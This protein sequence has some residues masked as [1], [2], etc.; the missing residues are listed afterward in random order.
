MNIFYF[1][2]EDNLGTQFSWNIK[3][4]ATQNEDAYVG[5]KTKLELL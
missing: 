2:N 4:V 5:V 1:L 3:T